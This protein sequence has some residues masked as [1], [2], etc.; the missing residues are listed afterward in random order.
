MPAKD[1]HAAATKGSSSYPPLFS[2]STSTIV[3]STGRSLL[4]GA[5]DVCLCLPVRRSRQDRPTPLH[6]KLPL[7]LVW[8]PLKH[9]PCDKHERKISMSYRATSTNAAVLIMTRNLPTATQ[10]FQFL[11]P[12]EPPLPHL[13]MTI[14]SASCMQDSSGRNDCCPPA[15]LFTLPTSRCGQTPKSQNSP[16]WICC[17]WVLSEDRDFS[18]YHSRERQVILFK[19]QTESPFRRPPFKELYLSSVWSI[20]N[21]SNP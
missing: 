12:S 5:L 21:Q 8:P 3:A 11:R 19:G 14:R 7:P 10:H 16:R 15:A 4:R 18:G 1:K 2:G 9:K 6:G 20:G 17:A 13:A